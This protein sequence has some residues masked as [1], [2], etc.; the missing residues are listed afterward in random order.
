LS[1]DPSTLQTGRFG[2]NIHR[3]PR[4]GQWSEDN[5]HY[6]AGC[7]V[8]ADDRKFSEFLLMCEHAARAFGNRFT[9]TLLDEQ[10]LEA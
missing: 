9:Y 4:N 5:T 3:G 10:A 8:F 2:I 6:S 1:F 7:Q